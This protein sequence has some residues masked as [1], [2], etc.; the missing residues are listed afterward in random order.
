MEEQAPGHPIEQELVRSGRRLAKLEKRQGQVETELRRLREAVAR[1]LELRDPLDA[2]VRAIDEIAEDGRPVVA[3]PWL[4]ELGFEL[5]YWIP[6]LTWA[7]QR[8]HGLAERLAVVSRGGVASWYAHLT[9]R[10]ADVYDHLS[11]EQVIDLRGRR[12]KQVE[13]T[14]GELELID[15]VAAAE[16][17]SDHVLLHPHVLYSAL[18]PL[19]QHGAG[20]RFFDIAEPRPF[21]IPDSGPLATVLPEEFVA[22]K[23]YF[24]APFPDTPENAAFARGVVRRL[25]TEGPVV[26]LNTGLRTDDHWEAAIE[27]ERVVAL[28]SYMTPATNLAIQT[29]A[30]SRARAFVGTYGGLSYLAPCFGVPSVSF[31]SQ[32]DRFLRHHLDMAQSLFAREGF[33]GYLALGTA[34]TETFGR[35]LWGAP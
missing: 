16:G 20:A 27:A 2:A 4:G 21:T 17:L 6:F 5:L 15:S 10:Y 28:E 7:T 32:A 23:F 8:H 34:E 9:P 33:G 3:G 14:A 30:V 11:I 18:L 25:A 29:I 35:L 24:S 13:R 31:H 1:P 22:V 26:L 12:S 19:L